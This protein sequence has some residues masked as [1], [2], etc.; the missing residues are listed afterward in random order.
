MRT[1]IKSSSPGK[2]YLLKKKAAGLLDEIL[3]KRTWD[4]NND[5]MERLREQS[6]GVV[7]NGTIPEEVTGIKEK[8]ILNTACLVEKTRLGEFLN[9]VNS[10]RE[11]YEDA[12]LKF[13]C[14]GP[15]PPYNYC[16]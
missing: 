13:V 1:D 14:T 2:A 12:G 6:L 5:S 9:T 8:M 7:V 11:K 16:S 10:L 3:A 15:W 4:Y